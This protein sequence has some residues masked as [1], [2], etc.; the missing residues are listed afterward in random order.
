[1]T[2][3]T[4]TVM[5]VVVMILPQCDVWKTGHLRVPGAKVT[6]A[7]RLVDSKDVSLPL[8]CANGFRSL[9]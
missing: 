7:G 2:T 9:V 8:I 4:A 6:Y 1:M 3:T 5:M